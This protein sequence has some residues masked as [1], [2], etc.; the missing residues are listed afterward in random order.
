MR[1][2]CAT[3]HK[4]VSSNIYS[5]EN[6]AVRTRLLIMHH[7]SH[8][9]RGRCETGCAF[10]YRLADSFKFS[11]GYGLMF[12]AYDTIWAVSIFLTTSITRKLLIPV[13]HFAPCS[14]KA[15]CDAVTVTR[16]Q[17]AHYAKSKHNQWCNAV[18]QQWRCDLNYHFST[19]S[20]TLEARSNENIRFCRKTWQSSTHRVIHDPCE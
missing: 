10:I 20:S 5:G 8:H 14:L 13:I 19:V 18:H 1:R 11:D 9:D 7:A 6:Y 3:S 17:Y 2:R 12:I 16:T 4:N 15:F